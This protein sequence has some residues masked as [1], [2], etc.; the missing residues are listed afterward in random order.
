MKY[1]KILLSLLLFLVVLWNTNA[2]S[3]DFTNHIGMQFNNIRAGSFYIGSSK[4]SKNLQKDDRNHKMMEPGSRQ[5]GE[6]QNEDISDDLHYEKIPLH[7]VTISQ[8]FQMGICEVTLGQFKK[9]IA[10]SGRNDLLTADFKK[11]NCY[12]DDAPVVTVSWHDAQAFAKWLN[13]TKHASDNGI[14][15]LPSEVEWEYAARAGTT[16]RYFFGDTHRQL[17]Q[18]AWYF[19][20]SNEH[21]HVVAQKKPNPWGLYDIHGN[22]DEWVQDWYSETYYGHNSSEH[23]PNEWLQGIFRLLRGGSWCNLPKGCDLSTR[24][25]TTPDTRDRYYG[26]R[27]VRQPH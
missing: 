12:G 3:A 16:S 8:G 2:L 18:Y 21:Q 6:G 27:L 9:F 1:R 20:N 4:T 25:A 7:K 13:R 14:Y 10:G 22:V 26:F 23:N 17:D 5:S 15:R 24:V 11:S 19:N